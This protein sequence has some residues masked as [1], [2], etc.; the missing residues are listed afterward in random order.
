[1][2]AGSER[3]NTTSAAI[4]ARNHLTDANQLEIGQVLEILPSEQP[5]APP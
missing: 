4:L 1:M 3:F 2:L 5:P